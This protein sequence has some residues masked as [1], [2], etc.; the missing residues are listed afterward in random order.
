MLLDEVAH[1]ASFACYG[2]SI[3]SLINL[4]LVYTRVCTQV[5]DLAD[6]I[7]LTNNDLIMHTFFGHICMT[8]YILKYWAKVGGF[9]IT[10]SF[11]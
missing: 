1:A 4:V 9:I 10:S 6:D 8:I 3:S 2:V 7:V 5:Q 11:N